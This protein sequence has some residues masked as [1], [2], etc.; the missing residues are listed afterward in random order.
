MLGKYLHRY[1]FTK[2]ICI[3]FSYL[4]FSQV[5]M[6]QNTVE[7][8]AIP[9]KSGT[10]IFTP[11][12]QSFLDSIKN[13]KATDDM[14]LIFQLYV[15]PDA[16]V[17]KTLEDNGVKLMDYLGAY[18]YTAILSPSAI[19]SS[20][21]ANAIR[22]IYPMTA[23]WKMDGKVQKLIALKVNT[24]HLTVSFVKDFTKSQI[25]ELLHRN[26]AIVTDK[27]FADF[28]VYEINIKKDDLLKLAQEASVKYIT[29]AAKDVS[30]NNDERAMTGTDVVELPVSLG[31]MGLDGTG[32]T[33][34]VGDNT[35]ALFH[36]DTRDRVT[37]FNC[38][39]PE[40]H[41]QHV[42]GT[43]AGKGIM[44]PKGRGLAPNASILAH[45]YNI[46]WA[47]TQ[48]MFQDYNMTLT[49]N[50]YAAVVNDCSV[51]GTYDLYSQ[52]LDD[53]A[54]QFPQVLNV[55]AAGNDG[56]N[57]CSP[58]PKG[59]GTIVGVYQTAKNILTVS[60]LRKPYT[61]H[62]GASKGPVKDGRLKP[63]VVSFGAGI[64]SCD[65]Y[66]NY[67]AINGTS[68]ACPGATGC[69]TLLTERYKQLNSNANPDNALIKALL[70]NGAV[71]VLN[72]GPDFIAGF[73]LINVYRSL[74][75]LNNNRYSFNTISNNANQTVSINV[76]ANTAQLKVLLYWNDVSASPAATMTLVNDLDLTVI[77]PN[78]NLHH[79]MVLDSTPANVTNLAT[80]GTDHLNNVEQVVINNPQQGVFTATIS[81][82]NIPSASQSYYLV[83]D[84]I[85]TGITLKNPA[86]GTAVA[87]NDALNV[88]WDAS[89]DANTF[90]LEY[91]DNNGTS[92]NVIDNNIPSGSKFY[93]WNVPNISTAQALLRLKRNN[94]SI[95]SV[96]GNFVINPQP[97]LQLDATQCPGYFSFSWNAIA[98]ATSYQIL[99]K[100][101]ND[102][103]PIDTVT[104]T[105]YLLSGLP[106]NTLQYVAVAPIINGQI[107]YRSKALRRL[108]NDGSCNTSTFN[109]D[110]MIENIT[111]PQSG[112]KFTSTE[113]SVNENLVVSLRNLGQLSVANFKVS[114]T[115]NNGAW[116]SQTYTTTIPGNTTISQPVSN[117]DLAAIG[118]YQV[119]VAVEN[120]AANDPVKANDTFSVIV[121]QLANDPLD[122]STIF[123]DDFEASG[124]LL[125][126]KDEMGIL[127]GNYW[128]FANSSDSG[129]LRSFVEDDVTI[130]GNRSVSMDLLYNL[131]INQNYLYGT[132]NLSGLDA[133]NTE[134]RLELDYKF[135]GIPQ[136]QDGNDI[137][138][139]GNDTQPWVKLYDFDTSITEGQTTNT[140]SLS[141]T[142]VLLNNSQNFSTSFQV[143]IGQ[144]D[145]SAIAMND[146]GNGLTIDNFKLYSVKNDVQL[147]GVVNPVKLNC[148]LGNSESVTVKIYN[149]DNLPQKNI[150]VFYR[151]DNGNTIAENI[152]SLGA[153]DTMN[154]TF[155]QPANLAQIGDH[156]L[157]VWLVAVGDTY[158]GNDS[159]LDYS[160]R[161]QPVVSAFPYLENFE[162]NDGNWFSQGIN[163]SWEYGEPNGAKIKDAASGTKAWVTNLTGSYNNNEESYLYSPCFDVSGLQ[164]P[165]LSFS[166]STDIENCGDEICDKAYVEYSEDG[167][168]WSKLGSYGN[169]TNWYNNETVQIWNEQDNTRWRVASQLLPKSSS[170]K[171][172]F[173]FISDMGAAREGIAIDDIHIF[174]LKY[175]VYDAAINE[176][177]TIA[178]DTMQR[179]IVGGKIIAEILTSS[180][181]VG[182]MDASFYH[183]SVTYSPFVN[184]YYLPGNFSIKA[185]NAEAVG[186]VLRLFVTDEDF[187]KMLNDNSCNSCGKPADI[188]RMGVLKYD[189]ENTSYEN[190]AWLDNIHGQYDFIPYSSVSWIPYEKGYYV[191][192]NVSSFSEFWI[193][194]GVPSQTAH[195]VTVYPNPV[196]NN[197]INIGWV[198]N[199]SDHLEVVVFDV[200][201]QKV[202][203]YDVPA[204][205]SDNITTL[206]LPHLAS[207]V[208]LLKYKTA[209]QNGD[210]KI[211]VR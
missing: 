16:A 122:I 33:V 108:P 10:V 162:Q 97:V 209:L 21:L 57:T 198:G 72:P 42:T 140:G 158:T 123:V 25:I 38:Y 116:Q 133:S 69:A 20:F 53:N 15:L 66:D 154:Y 204:T 138:I 34:G 91:S 172:R 37:N 119:T 150:Q 179:F 102:L 61:E 9:M 49:N 96:S 18:A 3:V 99:H 118:T 63:E 107:G 23:D 106:L 148:G 144:K 73:G 35:P 157:D 50:S 159:V 189:D 84:F 177:Q 146:Y 22:C 170:L 36:V 202:A 197:Q 27:K 136:S 71:D 185:E 186:G 48:P 156:S 132:F 93:T 129:R 100:I 182:N 90:T 74:Q 187:L 88:Y 14:Q 168:K 183:H 206:N 110:L 163:N 51:A 111:A 194:T 26:N 77:E 2:V 126:Q 55:F 76:P 94:T 125:F 19:H 142:N 45:L 13:A 153:K 92:W 83:Y 28:N 165:M 12:A 104:N 149:S 39:P 46:V 101:G 175:P 190:G 127:S 29:V 155:L 44:D 86:T 167:I 192:V 120:L 31:G 164:N 130:G 103:Q 68:M 113:L 191:E 105:N 196:L 109:N 5:V 6:A 82:A 203:S 114:Y 79:P 64:Y 161:N 24:L 62:E 173:V 112:R 135:H 139:R 174:D 176:Y 60:S 166:L 195:T 80:E 151:L 201:G 56:N 40:L 81:G 87:A 141:L 85:P 180:S 121:K 160:L 65:L 32:V 193:T 41:G 184:Q 145:T 205:D 11:N 43:I 75:I 58:Y 4:A 8:Y 59:Y 89:D 17:R 70:I 171:L 211:T 199:R 134:A 47:Q 54:N 30:L 95:Q 131:P 78:N 52:M 67:Q 1:F 200:I 98:N 7:P 152:D 169:G 143:R 117:I 128:D 137:F 207:G 178:S 208:Y 147:L 188:Y 124:K 210:V 181:S 115:V